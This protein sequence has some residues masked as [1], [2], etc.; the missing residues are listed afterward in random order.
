M[1]D[2]SLNKEIPICTAPGSQLEPAIYED[3]IVWQD[4]RNGDYDIYLF[5]LS[6]MQE[7]PICREVYDQKHP[8]IWGSTVVW[9][10]DK[11]PFIYDFEGFNINTKEPFTIYTIPSLNAPLK[12]M[13]T[14]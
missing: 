10:V 11:G 4:D 6:T 14:K 12:F 1:Y 7:V 13:E 3:K 8:F 5:D 9:L 2:L